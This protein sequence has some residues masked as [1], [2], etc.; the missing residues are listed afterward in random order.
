V[1]PFELPEEVVSRFR[2]AAFERLEKIEAAWNALTHGG[3]NREQEQELHRDLHTL[4]GDA[5]VIGFTDVGVLCQRL[6]DLLAA[7]RERHYHVHEDVDIVVTM[8]I[9]F[10]GMLLRQ[11]AGAPRA[12]I[13]LEGFLRQIEEVLAEW[14]RRRS[15][16]APALSAPSPLH[17]RILDPQDRLSASAR[18]RFSIVATAVFLE[19]LR[20]Q[21]GASR[22]RL[23][24]IWRMLAHEIA[25]LDSVPIA[26]MIE[27]QAAAAGRLA[28]ELG[29]TIT[30]VRSPADI[31][32]GAEVFDALKTALLHTLRNAIDHGI[33]LP[34]VRK[35]NGKPG[36]AWVAVRA[37]L[38]D[39]G[40][41]IF[42]ED[43]GGGVDLDRVRRR[44]V[45]QQL[46]PP[47]ASVSDDDVLELGCRPGCSTRATVSDLSGRGVGLDAVRAAV[48]RVGGSVSMQSHPGAG[49]SVVIH[50][51]QERKTLDVLAF[52]GASTPVLFAVPATWSAVLGSAESHASVDMAEVLAL[53]AGGPAAT[54]RVVELRRDRMTISLAAGSVPEPAVARRVCS[55][56]QEEQVE[57]VDIGRAE[58]I[59]VRPE[60]ILRE[61]RGRR[62]P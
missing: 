16:A 24:D 3:A 62:G 46:L 22:S 57:V 33:E 34:E 56:P 59:L 20:V 61:R 12:G 52:R 7:A 6:E 55:T 9:Q 5:H 38:D 15:S 44:A 25:Q 19:H 39:S 2:T 49:T 30:I 31:A 37:V 17:V 23:R 29:K 47:D 26:P 51:P 50:V 36:H 13:D 54:P 21:S 43:D 11:K 58:A 32:V 41:R 4:K 28:L 8:G 42:V 27:R 35:A 45:E 48:T 60:V 18:D 14:V 10:A 53:P 40:A 1:A